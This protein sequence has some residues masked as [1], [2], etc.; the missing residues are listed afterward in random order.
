[1]YR[2]PLTTEQRIAI[3]ELAKREREAKARADDIYARSARKSLEA[4]EADD[5]EERRH[6]RGDE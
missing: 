5:R 4:L 1:M 3:R 6:C 2:P